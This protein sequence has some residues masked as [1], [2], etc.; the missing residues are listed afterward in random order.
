[1]APKY[2]GP[3]FAELRKCFTDLVRYGLTPQTIS[4]KGAVLMELKIICERRQPL[5]DSATD[6]AH[7]GA[8]MVAVLDVLT[9]AI[10]RAHIPASTDRRVLRFVLPIHEN[11]RGA[12]LSARRTAAGENIFDGD[13][14]LTPGTIRTSYEPKALD[15]LGV[16]LVKL[17]A[18]QRSE[19]PPTGDFPRLEPEP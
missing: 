5:P 9:K 11:Y 8:D 17:E 3:P 12:S 10:D 2:S 6:D 14:V 13:R 7:E 16:V 1:M 4:D 15:W 18:E 19:T